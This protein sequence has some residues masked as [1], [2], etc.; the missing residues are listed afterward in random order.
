[1]SPEF[2]FLLK[3]SQEARRW[4][5]GADRAKSPFARLV[6]PKVDREAFQA[7]LRAWIMNLMRQ[8]AKELR[9]ERGWSLCWRWA[10][11]C[12]GVRLPL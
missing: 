2:G 10:V 1:M 12:G 7:P 6:R 3:S 9:G 4:S 8:G 11:G 5:C